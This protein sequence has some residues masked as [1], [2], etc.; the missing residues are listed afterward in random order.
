MSVLQPSDTDLVPSL[1]LERHRGG[2]TS[3]GLAWRILGER[4]GLQ[5]VPVL[6]PGHLTL[7]DSSG[8]FV[9]PLRGI[10]RSKAFY[11]SAFLLDRRP[12]YAGLSP[13]PRGLE[14]AMAVQGG[15]L[16]WKDGRLA[17]ALGAFR[18]AV[19][20]AP[21]LPEGEGNLGLVFEAMG[22]TD[23]ARAHLAVAVAGDSLNRSAM[24]RLEALR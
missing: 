15:L 1:S 2:C 21:G 12:F 20:L 3:L 22:E 5:L 7:R 11:D 10:E 19:A 6:L 14:A 13:R 24:R 23:S 8:R 17:E 18:V 9:E 16:A 4:V